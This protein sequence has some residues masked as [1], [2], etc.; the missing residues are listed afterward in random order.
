MLKNKML[1]SYFPSIAI[2]TYLPVLYNTILSLSY[3]IVCTSDSLNALLPAPSL[4]SNPCVLYI[5]ES[6][7]LLLHS[8]V[9]C[10]ILIPHISDIIQY[11]F[12]SV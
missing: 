9:C 2:K 1:K 10:I 5:C 11:L 3:T 4:T 6:A 12:F 8:L 7:S